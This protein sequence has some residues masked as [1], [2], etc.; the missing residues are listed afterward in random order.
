M[1]T[2][3]QLMGRMQDIPLLP[4]LPGY[5][6]FKTADQLSGMVNKKLDTKRKI[7]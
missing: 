6:D 3:S 4:P 1:A 2:A 7:F 5:K